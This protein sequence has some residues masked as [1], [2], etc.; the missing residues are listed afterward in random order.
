MKAAVFKQAGVPL[1]V[2]TVP[3]PE[4]GAG[5]V[6]IKVRRCGVCGTDLH[7]TSGRGNDAPSNSVIG[8]EYCGE[9]VAL[10]RGVDSLKIGQF[11]TAMPVA[12]CG[13]CVQCLTGYPMACF[14]MQG[15][16]GGFGEYMRISAPS[17]II[18]PDALSPEDGALVE[19]LAVGL[20]GVRLAQMDPGARIAVLGAGSIGLAVIYWARL[21]GAGR[22]VAVSR[23][24][25]RAELAGCRAGVEPAGLEADTRVGVRL[26][27]ADGHVRRGRRAGRR[28]FG[29][30]AAC[31]DR[32]DS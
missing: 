19:P 32:G 2:E 16:V 13:A 14:Q 23:S 7:M 30:S 11:V 26:R 4:P 28:R 18:L 22:I 27:G 29:R 3:D 9:I 15:R 6:V 24:E 8:H 10:G 21:L 31:G 17:T 5:E 12:G 25:R 1:V 20:R